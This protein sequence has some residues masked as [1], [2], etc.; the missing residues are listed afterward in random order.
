MQD[1]QLGQSGLPKE[2]LSQRA[3]KKGFSQLSAVTRC[4]DV[5]TGAPSHNTLI[6]YPLDDLLARLKVVPRAC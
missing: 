6:I 2:T 1:N 5:A 4:N 3:T